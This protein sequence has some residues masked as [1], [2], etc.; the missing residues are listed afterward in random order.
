[1]LCILSSSV[2]CGDICYDNLVLVIK[3]IIKKGRENKI[4]V[5]VNN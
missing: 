2:I 3:N 1:V 5:G 4:K